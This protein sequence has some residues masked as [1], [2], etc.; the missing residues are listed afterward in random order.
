MTPGTQPKA[1][2]SSP[3]NSTPSNLSSSVIMNS[4]SPTPSLQPIPSGQKHSNG[5][6]IGGI[7]AA[8]AIVMLLSTLGFVLWRRKNGRRLQTDHGPFELDRSTYRDHDMELKPYV[9]PVNL[10]ISDGRTLWKRSY[11]DSTTLSPATTPILFSPFSSEASPIA[12]NPGSPQAAD[13]SSAQ[14][15]TP[16]SQAELIQSLGERNVPQAELVAA[17]RML[18]ADHPAGEP[19]SGESV[20]PEQD[21]PPTYDSKEVRRKE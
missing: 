19:T 16:L 3:A 14:T 1:V 17:I 13:S 6:E 8:A 18:A 20:H 2:A 9:Q 11:E 10:S 5:E 21:P 12:W 4:A 15:R 7:V